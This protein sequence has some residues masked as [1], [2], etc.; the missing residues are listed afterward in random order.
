[1][2]TPYLVVVWKVCISQNS[3]KPVEIHSVKHGR[4]DVQVGQGT[5]ESEIV[6]AAKPPIP[7]SDWFC[8]LYAFLDPHSLTPYVSSHH[9]G[10][11]Q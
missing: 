10:R 6:A 8:F 2:Y 3:R 9:V 7:D 4:E 5:D 11:P 1:V